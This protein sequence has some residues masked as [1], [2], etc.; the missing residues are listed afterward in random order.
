MEKNNK[1]ELNKKCKCDKINS[2][3]EK[4]KQ[5]LDQEKDKNIRIQAE[6]LNFKKRLDEEKIMLFKYA[7]EDILNSLLSIIDNFER[8]INMDDNDLTDEVSRFLSGFKM[9][10][11]NLQ[12]ILNKYDVKEIDASGVEFNPNYHQALLTEKDENKPSGVILEVLQKGYIY[13]D[14]VLRP[15][16]VK[17]NE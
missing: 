8:G 15:A 6:M 5:E 7:N 14:K 16:M 9:I 3:V 11:G 1:N 17:V 4:L 10:F 13:K 12:E 2:Q